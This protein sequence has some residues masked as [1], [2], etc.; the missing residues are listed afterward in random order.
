MVATCSSRVSVDHHRRKRSGNP[1]RMPSKIPAALVT[2]SAS[3]PR[4]PGWF[5]GV[6]AA[7]F[8]EPVPH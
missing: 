6:A 8:V 1:E 2:S 3:R 5:P 4:Q 7:L